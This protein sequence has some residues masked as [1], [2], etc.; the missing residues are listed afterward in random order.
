MLSGSHEYRNT[1]LGLCFILSLLFHASI[2]IFLPGLSLPA[3][4]EPKYTE[5]I[6]VPIRSRVSPQKLPSSPTKPQEPP[7]NPEVLWGKGLKLDIKE[8]MELAKRLTIRVPETLSV[9]AS[10]VP[11][12]LENG[13]KSEE[14]YPAPI[15]F[16]EFIQQE[17]AQ[18]LEGE[19]IVA[20]VEKELLIEEPWQIKGPAGQRKVIFKPPPPSLQLG[21]TME[22]ELKF[23][24]LPDGSVGRIIPSR[25]GD[26]AL[27]REMMA[28]LKKWR[29][30]PLSP[31]VPQEE[32][33]GTIPI[34]YLLK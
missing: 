32:Q 2:L 26:M 13:P 5:V 21:A 1:F 29:F 3:L 15:I 7:I 9:S 22:I 8:T 28:Y 34:K 30:N 27:E 19:E 18:L 33:W 6:L 24:V 14:P 31:D 10:E 17:E 11:I 16:Q 4:T 20:K 12:E 23:W 25:R